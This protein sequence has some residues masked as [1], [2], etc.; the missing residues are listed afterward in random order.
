MCFC[1][2]GCPPAPALRYGG[3]C[4]GGGP[5]S[6][7]PRRHR[8]L[9]IEPLSPSPP[10]HHCQCQCHS[11]S[12]WEDFLILLQA[13]A[14]PTDPLC[15]LMCCP[16]S[17]CSPPALYCRCTAVPGGPLWLQVLHARPRGSD[18]AGLCHRLPPHLH[19]LPQ[20]VQLPETLSAAQRSLPLCAGT[21]VGRSGTAVDSTPRASFAGRSG[22][23]PP[24]ATAHTTDNLQDPLGALLFSF[25][26][27]QRQAQPRCR[28]QTLLRPCGTPTLRRLAVSSRAGCA[29]P[30][31]IPIFF[32]NTFFALPPLCPRFLYCP[33][34][35][36]SV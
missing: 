14:S 15:P 25:T 22:A 36:F 31:P 18:P 21:P 1:V 33:G 35:I 10:L 11:A 4:A 30:L 8:A 20:I 27:L 2:G 26:M 19:P 7:A 3:W 32:T 6:A 12:S 16:P 29:W 24:L 28:P 9:P 34:P 23:S 17:F 13:S 5:H